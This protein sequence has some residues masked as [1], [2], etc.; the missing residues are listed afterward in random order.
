[1][2]G[3]GRKERFAAMM[4]GI[5]FKLPSGGFKE[6]HPTSCPTRNRKSNLHSP[7]SGPARSR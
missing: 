2:V 5:V 1:M 4:Q 7:S 3:L 6:T